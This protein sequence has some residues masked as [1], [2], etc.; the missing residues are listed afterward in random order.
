MARVILS[1][2][3]A[4]LPRPLD[5]AIA[6]GRVA[7][8]LWFRSA[9][10]STVAQARERISRARSLWPSGSRAIFSIDEEGGLIQQLDGLRDDSGQTWPRLPSARSLGRAGDASFAF[11]HGRETGRRLRL[12]GLDVDLA[13]VVHLDPGGES[14]V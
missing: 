3:E 1:A 7:G 2:R 10:G 8:L 6:Q 4:E 9:L 5:R 13:P 14:G 11:A 12:L